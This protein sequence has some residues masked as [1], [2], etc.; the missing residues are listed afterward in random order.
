MDGGMT[1]IEQ[2]LAKLTRAQ[3]FHG[4]FCVKNFGGFIDISLRVWRFGLRINRDHRSPK[5]FV[6]LA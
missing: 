6:R 4:R 1:N 2:E 5:I 3:W